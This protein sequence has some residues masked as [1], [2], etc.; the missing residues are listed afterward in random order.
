MPK[1]TTANGLTDY[2]VRVFTQAGFLCWR[3]NTTGL[4][5]VQAQVFRKSRHNL[6]GKSDVLGFHKT[7]GR[8][9]ACEI[10]VG[11][12]RLSVHQK[13]FL[14]SVQEAGG[15][16]LVIGHTRDLEPYLTE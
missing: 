9:L 5:D 8:F 16:A 13:E 3:E 12:D 11:A 2:A 15:L 6:R 7:T 10:K 14:Q 4:W 1:I